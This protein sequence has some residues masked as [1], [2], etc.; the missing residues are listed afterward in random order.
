MLRRFENLALSVIPPIVGPAVL[1][2]LAMIFFVVPTDAS[3]GISQ[4]IFYFHVS[5]AVTSLLAFAG[6]GAVSYTHLTLPTKRI[7]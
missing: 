7:V 6:A 3:L 2:C 5:A 4:R 1:A